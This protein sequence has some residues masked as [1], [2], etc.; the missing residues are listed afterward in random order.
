[1]SSGKVCTPGEDAAKGHS[2]AFKG[3]PQLSTGEMLVHGTAR[4]GFSE[5][6]N[7]MSDVTLITSEDLQGCVDNQSKTDENSVEKIF[8]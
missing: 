5:N 6:T 1:M 3:R 7:E 4:A 2:V 8:L